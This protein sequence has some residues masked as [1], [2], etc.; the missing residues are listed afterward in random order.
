MLKFLSG[1]FSVLLFC[2]A[3]RNNDK[4]EIKTYFDSLVESNTKHLVAEGALVNKLTIVGQ[5]QDTVTFKADS[6]QWSNELD[7]FRQLSTF[8]RPAYRDDYLLTDGIKD[9]QS[10]LSIREFKA[11]KKV[12]V[13]LVRFYYFNNLRQLK[14]IEADYSDFNALY[15]SSRHLLMEFDEKNGK[16]VLSHYFIEGVQQMILSDKE[17]Y[18]ING[19]ITY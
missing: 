4:P 6:V 7:A 11:T 2:A 15:S 1:I 12:P 18:T 8:Q 10:N 5:K 16:P 14:K 17:S 9:S 13:T 3:C 19:T